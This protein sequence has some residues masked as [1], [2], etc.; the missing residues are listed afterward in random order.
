MKYILLK[1]ASHAGKSTT[2]DAVCKMIKPDRIRRLNPNAKT[3]EDIDGIDGM[4][5]GSFILEVNGMILLV[6]A[7]ATTEQGVTITML[8]KIAI[9]LKIRIDF[10]IVS[11]RSYEMKSGFNTPTE[12]KSLGECIGTFVIHKVPGDNF[13]NSEHWKARVRGIVNLLE[14]HGL[15]AGDLV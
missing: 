2:M 14:E 3:L 9:D 8:V 12:L 7:G 1:G 11:M 6:A 4:L 10:A 15:M 13:R 5:N